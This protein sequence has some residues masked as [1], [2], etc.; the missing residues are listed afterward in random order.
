VVSIF[1]NPTQFGPKED[2]AKYPRPFAQDLALC[3]REGVDLL[4]HPTPEE[5]YEGDSSVK[6]CESSLSTGLCGASRLGHFNGV[7]TVVAMLFQII[8]PDIAIFGEKDWQQVA[9]IRRMVRDLKMPVKILSHATVREE[10]GLALSSRNRLLSPE[11]RLVAPRIYQALLTALMAAEAGETSVASLRRRLTS[12][13]AVIPR[14]VVDY[15]EIVD[16]STLLPLQKLTPGS[17]AR[18]LVAVQLGSVRLIDNL[19]I[20]R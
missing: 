6:V 3:K 19:G 18:A 2:L 1:V 5:M 9:V 12:D 13:L 17:A 7:C 15:A 8:R 10:D 11:S 16:E 20:S 4:F 14:T